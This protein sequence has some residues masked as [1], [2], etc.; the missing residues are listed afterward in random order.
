MNYFADLGVD[1]KTMA[2]PPFRHFVHQRFPHLK[3][4]AKE[5]VVSESI[6]LAA[7]SSN[8][9]TVFRVETSQQF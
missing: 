2:Y 3:F 1:S 7:A 9:D 5:A 6:N 8:T 4:S